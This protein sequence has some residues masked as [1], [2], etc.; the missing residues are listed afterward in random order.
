[1]TP[2]GKI[3]A[4]VSRLLKSYDGIWYFMPVPSGYG[5]SALDYIGCYRGL[6]FSVETKAPGKSPTPRQTQCIA[7]MRR[8]SGAVFVVTNDEELAVLKE[9]FDSQ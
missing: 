7:S 6:F 2:E 5:E 3:K 4:K 8:A 9:W 1:M